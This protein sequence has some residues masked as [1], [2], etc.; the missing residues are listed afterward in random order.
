MRRKASNGDRRGGGTG[1]HRE[2]ELGDDNDA[3]GAVLVEPVAAVATGRSSYL[4]RGFY[5]LWSSEK[6]RGAV[7]A[8]V[9]EPVHAVATGR[10]SCSFCGF[11][12][13]WSSEKKRGA[14]GAVV[15]EPIA[16]VAT[17]RMQQLLNLWLDLRRREER[18]I[19]VFVKREATASNGRALKRL[20]WFSNFF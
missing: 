5:G 4:I 2:G 1:E 12:G 18:W 7:G 20:L 11:Y 14:M 13:L 8:V 10:N 15:V 9:V 16:A 19:C 3:V 17:G 6:K